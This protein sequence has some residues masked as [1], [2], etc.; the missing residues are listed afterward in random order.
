MWKAVIA[1]ITLTSIVSVGFLKLPEKPARKPKYEVVRLDDPPKSQPP[2]GPAYNH[3][4]F[5]AALIKTLEE[6][7]A[8]RKATQP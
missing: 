1:L 4:E 3:A 2:Q 8:K 6:E 7:A 5:E